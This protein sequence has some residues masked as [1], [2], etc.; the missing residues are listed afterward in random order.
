M[1]KTIY[2]IFKKILCFVFLL[3]I[4]NYVFVQTSLDITGDYTLKNAEIFLN[5]V[6]SGYAPK[7]FSNLLPGI[8]II[9]IQKDGYETFFD[10]V[11]LNKDK[12]IKLIIN[13]DKIKE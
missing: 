3:S 5:N 13:L 8:Y 6:S 10:F 1:H 9:E 7:T 12:E 2:K 4:T 11:E